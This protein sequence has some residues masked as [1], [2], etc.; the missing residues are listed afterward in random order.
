M[1]HLMIPL[2]PAHMTAHMKVRNQC[3]LSF[4]LCIFFGWWGRSPDLK[5]LEAESRVLLMMDHVRVFPIPL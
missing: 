2:R 5:Q 1:T 4:I 3:K